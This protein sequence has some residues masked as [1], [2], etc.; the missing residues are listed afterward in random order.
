LPS[1]APPRLTTWLLWGAVFL[2]VAVVL[3]TVRACGRW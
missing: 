2:V 1:A 3:V